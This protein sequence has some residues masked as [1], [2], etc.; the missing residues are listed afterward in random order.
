MTTVVKRAQTGFTLIEL[1]IVIVL[2]GI[3]AV[4]AAPKFLNLQKD[5]Q[6]GALEGLR[7]AL[8]SSANV[9]YAKALI[10]GATDSADTTLN[11]GIRVRYGYPYA[12]Q[13]NMNNLPLLFLTA[14]VN[15]IGQVKACFLLSHKLNHTV[16]VMKSI[17]R[18]K[19]SSAWML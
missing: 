4:T 7:A 5:A 16:E 11:S 19:P 14:I 1:I 6:Q 17:G 15:N 9:V 2:L 18:F 12:T 8:T 3:L 13:T 10:E